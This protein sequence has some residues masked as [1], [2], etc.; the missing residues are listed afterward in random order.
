MSNGSDQNGQG[1]SEA[2]LPTDHRRI[3]A[4]A[5]EAPDMCSDWKSGLQLLVVDILM[6]TVFMYI[7]PMWLSLSNLKY[8]C[9]WSVIL[10]AAVL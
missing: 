10:V 7:L 6:F 4:A 2:L 5:S 3:E 9:V 1:L 8:Y